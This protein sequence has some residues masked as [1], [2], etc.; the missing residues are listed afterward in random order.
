MTAGEKL[1]DRY[2]IVRE[3]GRGGAGV[4]Y[5][6]RD[7]GTGRDVVVKLL[8]VGLLGDWKTA[9][10]FQREAAVLS[11]LHHE[12]IPAW[13]DFFPLEGEGS[14]R[15]VLVREFVDGS[16]L[17]SRVDT[18]WR[19][20]EEQ[21]RD[22]G[23]RLLSIV[24]YIHDVRP[25]VI[26]RDINP[27]NVITRS[28][29]E[30]FLVDFGG[31]QD[32]IRLSTGATTTI[33]GTPGYTPMEQFVGRATVRSDLYSVASTLLFLLTHR[34]PA[35]LPVKNLKIDIPSVIEITSR[36]LGRVLDNWLEPDE[37]RRTLSI[38]EATELL[39]HEPAPAV[40]F[41]RAPV[42]PPPRSPGEEAVPG[43]VAPSPP[44]GSKIE[45]TVEGDGVHFLLP[46]GAA[47][48]A[49]RG[50]APFGAFWIVFIGIWGT[51]TARSGIPWQAL[52]TFL[53]LVV[54]GVAMVAVP[55][56]AALSRLGIAIKPD[57][58]TWTRRVLFWTRRGTVPLED[59]GECRI[60]GSEEDATRQRDGWEY[61]YGYG[62]R[63][64][65]RR[66]MRMPTRLMLD[67]GARTLRFGETLSAREREWLRDA[68]NEELR[69]ARGGKSGG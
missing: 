49:R 6:A 41:P 31:V 60:E 9:E 28:D 69:V 67:V 20:T 13:V 1:S 8:H 53:P 34:N 61:G 26:H 46:P 54:V 45:K 7:T 64:R 51:Q 47:G 14:P 17:Q 18:G 65:S 19:G 3:L 62:Y 5:L 22:I 68:I 66:A 42:E 16:S 38:A 56:A 40:A 21:I 44:H 55:I 11:Q 35:D 57:G 25:P 32:A 52:L 30:V 2:E 63:S 43:P 39:T 23:I 24:R 4:T 58:L 15:F 36:G 29:G 33:V 59:V 12:R 48:F 27:R 37:A 10:L 50:I